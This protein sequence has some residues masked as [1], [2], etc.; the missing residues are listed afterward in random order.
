MSHSN[1]TTIQPH[2]RR[3]LLDLKTTGLTTGL[4]AI[5]TFDSFNYR[6]YIQGRR[7]QHISTQLTRITVVHGRRHFKKTVTVAVN[8]DDLLDSGITTFWDIVDNINLEGNLVAVDDYLHCPL[9]TLRNG[10][11][12]NN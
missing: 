1:N 8:V 2:Q 9:Q 10:R 5:T 3:R 12:I 7:Y 4:D 6:K 11:P